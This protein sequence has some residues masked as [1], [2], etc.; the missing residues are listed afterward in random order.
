MTV[1]TFKKC[2]EVME[3]LGDTLSIGGGEPTMHPKFWEI[4]GLSLGSNCESVWMATN[5]KITETALRLANMAKKGVLAVALSQDEWHDEIDYEVVS[6]FTVDNLNNG[7]G[8]NNND[9]REIRT[10]ST[11]SN[12]GRA[13]ENGIGDSESCVCDDTV[14][15]P[16]GTVFA[17]GCLEKQL[18]NIFDADIVKKICD[19]RNER[20][21]ENCSKIEAEVSQD[22]A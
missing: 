7:Y 8:K 22:V 1:K 12:I 5:G 3:S 10:V 14:V 15:Q 4:I 9:M 2:L 16:D 13:L 20:N 6:A 17:C 18:G 21:G 19:F 11:L